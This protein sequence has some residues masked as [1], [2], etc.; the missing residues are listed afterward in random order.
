MSFVRPWKLWKDEFEWVD[1]RGGS[2]RNARIGWAG[3]GA[4]LAEELCDEW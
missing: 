4:L 2:A 1:C 3:G